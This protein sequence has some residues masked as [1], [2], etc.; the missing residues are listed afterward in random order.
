[1]ASGRFSCSLKS[2]ISFLIL[3]SLTTATTARRIRMRDFVEGG[4]DAL[5]ARAFEDGNGS[6]L[7]PQAAP[8]KNFDFKGLTL[9]TWEEEHAKV[10]GK[11]L[12][13][14]ESEKSF[15][16]DKQDG[17]LV[18]IA[19]G[20][21]GADGAVM[22]TNSQHFRTEFKE[23]KNF[24]PKNGDYV[25]TVTLI[26]DEVDEKGT[27][28]G[29]VH[30]EDSDPSHKPVFELFCNSKGDLSVGMEQSPEG[31]D[32]EKTSVGNVEVGTKLT[33]KIKYTGESAIIT[34]NGEEKPPV[35]ASQVGSPRSYFKFGNYNQGH[36]TA[37]L[38][39]TPL[40]WTIPN[41]LSYCERNRMGLCPIHV[42]IF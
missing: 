3:I 24:D 40:S 42:K 6:N 5:R 23:D 2:L 32:E 4:D 29:Q 18:M 14:F 28:I 13:G 25:L 34:I 31:G 16:T 20:S 19:P 21:G 10:S 9:Q 41:K 22:T 35:K 8:S 26:V 39:S 27:C 17:S 12:E 37:S 1:M 38:G 11:D 33:Y 7:D 15:H 30:I 36:K